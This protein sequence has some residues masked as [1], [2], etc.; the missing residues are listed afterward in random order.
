MMI[1]L[2]TLVGFGMLLSVYR[3]GSWLGMSSALLTVA[4]LIQ[5]SPLLQKFWFS[6]FITGFDATPNQ[7]GVGAEIRPF[8][9]HYFQTDIDSSHYLMKTSLLACIALLT[10][11]TAFIGRLNFTQLLKLIVTYSIMWNLN[12]MIILYF[13]IMR[14]D[15]DGANDNAP[16]FLDTFGSSYVYLF[17]AVFGMSYNMFLGK[18]KIPVTHPRNIFNRTSLTFALIGTG[19]IYATFI[20]VTN[21]FITYNIFGQNISRFSIFFALTGSVISCYIASAIFGQGRVGF[22]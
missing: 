3:F 12:Y 22:K 10:S 11:M 1:M 20:F 18:Q 6:V 2:F 8:Y 21:E 16:Y 17:G 9:S 13:C 15:G 4:V 14:F 5:Y 19:F 7:S